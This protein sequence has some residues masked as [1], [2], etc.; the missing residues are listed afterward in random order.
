MRL[1]F[2]FWHYF[3]QIVSLKF[4]TTGSQPVF[5]RTGWIFRDS[6]MK[7]HEKIR[8]IR[9]SKHWSQEDMAEK[10]NM[11]LNGYVKIERGEV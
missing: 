7:V 8:L 5:L 6:L 2:V 11:S 4:Q 3:V 1:I 10:L 9:E